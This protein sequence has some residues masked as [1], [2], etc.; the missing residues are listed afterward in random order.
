MDLLTT[1]FLMYGNHLE[2]HV[3]NLYILKQASYVFDNPGRRSHPAVLKI[4]YFENVYMA[5]ECLFQIFV[6]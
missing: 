4:I 1:Y 5:Y 6:I 2:N 3:Y